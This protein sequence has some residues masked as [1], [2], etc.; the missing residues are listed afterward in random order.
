MAASQEGLLSAVQLIV[1]IMMTTISW[2]AK[3]KD[4]EKERESSE[5]EI[6]RSNEIEIK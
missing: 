4:K 3:R 2:L 1:P 6:R 5:K